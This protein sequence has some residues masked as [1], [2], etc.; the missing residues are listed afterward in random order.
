[1]MKAS[2]DVALIR[3]KED[4]GVVAVFVHNKR[5]E[6]IV[7][8]ILLDLTLEQPDWDNVAPGLRCWAAV[9]CGACVR[10]LAEE[11]EQEGLVVHMEDDAP[12]TPHHLT[13]VYVTPAA[14]AGLYVASLGGRELVTSRQPFLDVARVLLAEGV[15][16]DE[17]LIMRWATTGTESLRS[18]VAAAAAL[19]V[20][21]GRDGV[22]RFRPWRPYSVGRASPVHSS[23]WGL[24]MTAPS[25]LAA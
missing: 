24:T 11:A 22:P 6:I 19:T 12:E 16:P 17:I 1:M 25:S 5:A 8:R 21:D 4:D 15:D 18:T 23:D 7:E 20:E 3:R 13:I 14:K 9:I 2:H 10:H